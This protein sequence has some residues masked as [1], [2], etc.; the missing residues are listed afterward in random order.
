MPTFTAAQKNMIREILNLFGPAN[1][2]WLD[3]NDK[4]SGQITSVPLGNTITFNKALTEFNARISD[5]E[6][7]SDPVTGDGRLQ[8]LLVDITTW[9]KIR[10]QPGYF[11]SGGTAGSAGLRYDPEEHRNLVRDRVTQTVGMRV[12]IR[13]E[14]LANE[15]TPGYKQDVFPGVRGGNDSM[16]R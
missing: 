11:S 12:V 8:S 13:P 7:K 4:V 16:S 6:S 2:A 5:I 9:I 15:L 14:H 10:T 3:Y 1:F